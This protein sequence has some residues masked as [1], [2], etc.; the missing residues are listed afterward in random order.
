M[1]TRTHF[2]HAYYK[3]GLFSAVTTAFIAVALDLLRPEPNDETNAL[4]RVLISYAANATV[5]QGITT[6]PASLPFTPTLHAVLANTFFIA[7][8]SCSIL[9]AFGAVLGKQWI[10]YANQPITG[11]S[12]KGHAIERQNRLTAGEKWHLR[13]VLETLPV[14]LQFSL[15]MFWVALVFYLWNQSHIVAYTAI[16]FAVSG[17]ACYIYFL[18]A[19]MTDPYCPFHTPFSRRLAKIRS[20]R[21][22]IA[23]TASIVLSVVV[24]VVRNTIRMIRLLGSTFR[25]AYNAATSRKFQ[26]YLQECATD[27]EN[28]MQDIRN[29]IRNPRW[30]PAFEPVE[31]DFDTPQLQVSTSRNERAESEC[32]R[33]LFVQ[34]EDQEGVL[35]EAARKLPDI[36]SIDSVRWLMK[37]SL[38]FKRLLTQFRKGIKH[39]TG[40]S[41]T[42]T[43]AEEEIDFKT[44]VTTYATAL[45]HML[46]TYPQTPF[47]PRVLNDLLQ[48]FR[49]LNDSESPTKE[50]VLL[51]HILVVMSSGEYEYGLAQADFERIKNANWDSPPSLATRN[52]HIPVLPFI[53]LVFALDRSVYLSGEEDLRMSFALACSRELPRGELSACWHG[54]S[55]ACRSLAVVDQLVYGQHIHRKCDQATY[56]QLQLLNNLLQNQTDLV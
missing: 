25:S 23:R 41:D 44:H 4:L 21:G 37:R 56:L 27:W 51:E 15:F 43:L 45:T 13:G 48:E 16:G 3:A 35:L 8:L 1:P 36:R 17:A 6:I 40:T 2:I 55:P 14:I 34:V 33:W 19:A 10:W 9:A 28:L 26:R 42:I 29:F 49:K 32:V 46:L 12:T 52:G 38:V 54:S 11:L 24:S 20:R 5:A 30:V 53:Y 22:Y 31:D 18:V 7:S 50:M 39:F 47:H